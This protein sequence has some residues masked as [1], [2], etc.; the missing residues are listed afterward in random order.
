MYT[1][2]TYSGPSL[3][4][5]VNPLNFRHYG[6]LL[7]WIYFQPARLIHYL[8]QS[9]PDLY[10]TTGLTALFRTFGVAAYRNLY[11]MPLAMTSVLLGVFWIVFELYGMAIVEVLATI[12]GG[13]LLGGI[14]GG[15]AFGIGFALTFGVAEGVAEGIA[16]GV[17]FSFT[18]GIA[19]G[20]AG[21]LLGGAAS[22]MTYGVALGVALG[23]SGGVSGR[24]G[25]GVVEGIAL[26]I[27]GGMMLGVAGGLT[28]GLALGIG[29]VVGA[30]RILLH[31]VE[32]PIALLAARDTSRPFE[33]I[34]RHPALWDSQA[35]LSL[36]R[37]DTM[38]RAC[39][40]AD[41]DRGMD[42]SIRIAVNPFQRWAVQR[43]LSHYLAAHPDPLR[44][45]Y[46]LTYS[47]DLD[48]YLMPP[49]TLEQFHLFPTRRLV[50]LGEL[51]QVCVDG[52]GGVYQGSQTMVWRVTRRRR[53]LAP[54]PLS[55][56]SAMLYEL[57]RE[58]A[59]RLVPD[60]V[61]DQR[62]AVRFAPMDASAYAGIRMLPGGQEVS[63]SFTSLSR[64]LE[65][66]TI[67]DLAVGYESIDWIQSSSETP[68]RESVISVIRILGEVSR[69]IEIQQKTTS[70]SQQYDMLNKVSEALLLVTETVG[71]DV[72]PPERSLLS[73]VI[74]Q[75]QSIIATE[76]VRLGETTLKR[77]A[78]SG[79]QG[80]QIVERASDG[81][82]RSISPFRNPYI[83]GSPVAPPLFVR[84]SVV[85]ARIREILGAP[86]MV[87]ALTISGAPKLGV[88]SLL[89]NLD[90][91]TS[92]GYILM[93]EDMASAVTLVD[94]TADLLL[95]MA[96]NSS[97][98]CGEH[99]R[100]HS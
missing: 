51:G 61:R 53:N 26:G 3:P 23:I 79:R 85:F 91:A 80:A 74:Q 55:R 64:F 27:G 1:F 66:D 52:S 6:M 29:L 47:P 93:Y 89:H 65:I 43:S 59:N 4:D 67:Q 90:Q 21:V 94:S 9:D 56:L 92:P 18:F 83:A 82:S 24:V 13:V 98:P 97:P 96:D 95:G 40:D 49:R 86:T 100:N 87:H 20:L 72:F 99:I 17:S 62:T 12:L 46:H 54:T 19:E 14:I 5:T 48:H 81:F 84:H 45:L 25:G 58:E 57:L 2:P 39:L 71:T 78:H 50:L 36:P 38:L 69:D 42:L 76:Q 8:H 15:T 35:V 44:L 68:I 70:V 60:D 88:T 28:F 32:W 73:R 16:F 30:S 63:D 31:L 41:F 77:I 7:K 10:G 11:L 75:W 33:A 34:E 37:T 22:G